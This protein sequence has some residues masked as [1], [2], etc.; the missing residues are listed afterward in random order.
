MERIVCSSFATEPCIGTN[1]DTTPYAPEA[2][3]AANR[4]R[5]ASANQLSRKTSRVASAASQQTRRSE[6]CNQAPMS[7]IVTPETKIRARS[8][9]HYGEN[10][11]LSADDGSGVSEQILRVSPAPILTVVVLQS[12]IQFAGCL[13]V[14]KTV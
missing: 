7:N 14:R 2:R 11:H 5:S 8:D 4:F 9:A 6:N 10:Y 3:R 12:L 1:T 13:A